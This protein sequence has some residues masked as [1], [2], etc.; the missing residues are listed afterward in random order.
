MSRRPADSITD[1][2]KLAPEAR[3]AIGQALEWGEPVRVVVPG[4]FSSALV[5]TDRRMLIWKKR[6]LTAFPLDRL[7]AIAFGGGP[8]VRWV[9]VRGPESGLVRPGLLNIGEL[10]DAVQVGPEVDVRARRLLEMLI[11][12]RGD[13]RSPDRAHQDGALD[14]ADGEP[15]D[16]PL[17]PLE[18]NGAGGRLVVYSDRVRIEHRGF[19]GF[20]RQA[21]PSVAE[22]RLDDIAA[23]EWRDPGPLRLGRFGLHMQGRR[24]GQ[25]HQ[26]E[27]EHEVL[28]YLH[29]QL[30]FRQARAAIERRLGGRT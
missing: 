25:P 8:F 19:R 2:E 15:D 16:H 18:A 21:L 1:M 14:V 23:I 6:R 12:R 3:A 20:L 26:A 22:I 9:Q 17:L 7:D 4:T 29:Q 10:P 30:A 24:A 28:F 13:L 11:R 27:P 5:A